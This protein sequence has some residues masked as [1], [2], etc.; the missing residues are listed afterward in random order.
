MTMPPKKIWMTAPLKM[1]EGLA[2]LEA[3]RPVSSNCQNHSS[4]SAS[5]RALWLITALV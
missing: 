4:Y 5:V 3:V 1:Y 2:V